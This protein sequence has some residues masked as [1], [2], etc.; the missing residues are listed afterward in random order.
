[1]LLLLV[2]SIALLQC[3][4]ISNGVHGVFAENNIKLVRVPVEVSS[5]Q[6]VFVFAY[7]PSGSVVELEVSV[8]ITFSTNTTLLTPPIQGVEKSYRMRMTPI[9]WSPNWFVTQIPGLPAKTWVFSAKLP[10]TLKTVSV[11]FSVSSRVVYKL[12]VDGTTVASD[13]YVVKE[14]EVKQRLPP[15]VYAFVYEALNNIS[16]LNETL[17]LAPHGWVLGEVMPLKIMITAFDESSAPEIGFEYRVGEGTWTSAPVSDS[18]IMDDLKSFINDVSNAIKTV[19]DWVKQYSPGIEVSRPVQGVRLAEAIIPPQP[20]GTYVM[21][22]AIARDA[23]GNTMLSPMGLYYTVKVV[24]DTRILILDPHVMLWLLQENLEELGALMRTGIDYKVFNE[25][26]LGLSR[27]LNISK[28]IVAYGLVQFHHWEYL[29]KYYNLYISWPRREV[30]DIL[31]SFRPSVIILSSLIL[32]ARGADLWN[33][34]LR[35]I[36]VSGRSLLEHIIDYVKQSHA[37][38]IATHGTLSDEI[39]WL[40]CE[41]R[42]KVG[43]RGHVGYDLRDVNILNETTVATLLGM[44]ELALWEYV[45]D[46]VAKALCNLSKAL[47]ATQPQLAPVVMAT[48]LTV[49]S[50]PLQVPHVPWDGK[51]KL[52]PEAKDLGWDLPE[53]FEIEMPVLLSKYGFKAYTEVGWQLALPRA[54]AYVAWDNASKVRMDISKLVN[55]LAI[56]YENI[57]GRVVKAPELGMYF[58]R[59]V[60]HGLRGFYRGLN[61][62]VIR[63]LRLN[64]SIP[65]PE[66]GKA[67]NLSIDIGRDTLLNLL[68]RLPVKIVALSPNGL[69]GIVVHDKF[70][71]SQGYRAVYIS[72]E[73]E[74]AGGGAAEKILV[75]AVEWVK[76]WQY[77]DVTELLGNTVR[78]PKE[79]ASKFREA[80]ARAPGEK[81]F[82]DGVLLNEEGGTEIEL[83]AAPG[84]LHLVVAHPTADAI[85]IEI[86]KGFA[87][88]VNITKAGSR[89]TY[90]VIEVE[91][92]GAIV[93]SLRACSDTSLNPAYVSTKQEALAPTPTPTPAT[94]TV[95]TTVTTTYTTTQT[96]VV[97][98]VVTTTYVTTI[99]IPTTYTTTIRVYETATATTT[100]VKYE[101]VTTT[102]EKTV[103]KTT[104][105]TV[106]TPQTVTTTSVVTMPVEKTVTLTVTTL[107]TVYERVVDWSTTIPIA[108]ILLVVGIA[109]GYLIKRR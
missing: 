99:T 12:I 2:I 70:W 95:T 88:V 64:I 37:G 56:L 46:E 59:A 34:D 50:T 106:A 38:V 7:V 44:P 20:A 73:V 72:F 52:T 107:T 39:A 22:R 92:S 102:I 96:M 14:L 58:D 61:S 91:K 40:S 98:T 77:R 29:G 67:V 23:D 27:E 11:A 85:G 62:A 76:K 45:R 97:P 19:E 82:E 109:I 43:A 68:Q 6:P 101:T 75:N 51:L 33:W 15:I 26:T 94:V 1:L 108:V 89:V 105:L 104:T 84:K 35:D 41:S 21:F 32:G 25:I 87:K 30:V 8:S 17:G 13:S 49:G 86:V 3:V 103:E 93:L 10:L 74:A 31:K 5:S 66:L 83:S 71:D 54:I 16:I 57:T 24:S 47:E 42:A 90:A 48:A 65:V 53:E 55:R 80:V 63:G 60:D 4:L 9:P 69:A 18:S 78:V 100:V 81:L 79:T 36:T 28:N